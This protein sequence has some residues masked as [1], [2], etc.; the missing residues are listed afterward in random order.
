MINADWIITDHL[1]LSQSLP[2]PTTSFP[3]GWVIIVYILLYIYLTKLNCSALPPRP[4]LI[5][6]EYI[7]LSKEGIKLSSKNFGNLN[8]KLEV[9]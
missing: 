2:P 5:Y 8:K 6:S 4:L 1:G 7:F 9:L 3:P